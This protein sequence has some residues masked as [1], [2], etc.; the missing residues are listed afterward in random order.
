MTTKELEGEVLLAQVREAL[1]SGEAQRVRHESG[2]SKRQ[3]ADLAKVSRPTVVRYEL[4]DRAPSGPEGLR[5]ARVL[6]QLGLKV[7]GLS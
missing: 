2:L 7:R 5:Y 4:L 3:L 6:V 1:R